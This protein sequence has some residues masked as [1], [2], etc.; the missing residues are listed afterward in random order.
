MENLAALPNGWSRRRRRCRAIIETPQGRR[1]K[2]RY[3]PEAGLFELAFLLPEGLAFPFDFGFIPSTLGGDGDPLDV[4][5]LMDEPAH[6]GCLL[7][8]RVIGVLEATQREN[9]KRI[10]N[11]RLLGVATQS[12]GHER[13]TSLG[14][15]SPTLL[16]QLEGFLVTYNESRGKRFR[17]TGRS[18]PRRAATVLEA[19]IAAFRER[20]GGG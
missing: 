5:V 9:G 20:E 8:I 15:L 4:L 11:A 6:V 13:I 17:L 12:Y 1:A 7:E 16:S 2:F 19:G 18:G 3:D 14:D 10:D